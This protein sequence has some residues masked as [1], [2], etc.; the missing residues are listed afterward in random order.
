MTP[1]SRRLSALID[2]ADAAAQRGR[3]WGR[4]ALS[5]LGWL[6]PPGGARR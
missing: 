4:W 3:A 6:I 2:H 1:Y 5:L